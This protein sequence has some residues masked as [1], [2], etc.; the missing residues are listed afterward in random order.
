M[1]LQETK[2]K[3]IISDALEEKIQIDEMKKKINTK[4]I[5]ELK[6]ELQSIFEMRKKEL[7]SDDEY[8]TEKRAIETVLD[9]LQEEIKND[10]FI[11]FLNILEK[12]L[13]LLKN[14]YRKE[15]DTDFQKIS[16]LIDFF[17]SNFWIDKE[18]RLNIEVDSIL[19]VVEY[20]KIGDEEEMVPSIRIE[21]MTFWTATKRSI[22]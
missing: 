15:Q 5:K 13:E 12:I 2:C 17:V 11:S 21:P 18:K 22:H 7:I 3:D 8:L 19:N 20:G 9:N 4:K 10:D 1:T 16:W 6:K 14:G